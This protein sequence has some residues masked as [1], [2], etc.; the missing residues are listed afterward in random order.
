MLIPG[1]I[2]RSAGFLFASIQ[3]NEHWLC[4]LCACGDVRV[5]ATASNGQYGWK[6]KL[7]MDTLRITSAN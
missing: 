2:P 1:W 4:G 7:M 3:I 5:L 6:W